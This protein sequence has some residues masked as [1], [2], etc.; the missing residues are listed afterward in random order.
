MIM[1][2]LPDTATE[3]LVCMILPDSTDA[4][5]AARKA[6]RDALGDLPD[7]ELVVSELVTNAITHAS[8]WP[9]LV[10]RVTGEAVHVEVCDTSGCPPVLNAAAGAEHGRGLVIVDAL[11]R[12][13]GWRP[14]AAPWAKAVFAEIAIP[15]GT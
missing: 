11:C 5:S 14:A 10:A 4:P 13:W 3:P 2:K 15:E 1:A 12:C 7:V 8:G 6:V 9:L